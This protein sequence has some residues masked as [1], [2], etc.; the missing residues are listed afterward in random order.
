MTNSPNS[1]SEATMSRYLVTFTK[2]KRPAR[3]KPATVSLWLGRV[4]IV[5]FFVVWFSPLTWWVWASVLAI[6]LST[7][8][9]L[10]GKPVA[11]LKFQDR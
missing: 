11:T 6:H 7:Y 5:L 8:T 1:H 9:L 2:N 10:T 3:T 4:C